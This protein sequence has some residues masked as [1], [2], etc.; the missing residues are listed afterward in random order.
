MY[1]SDNALEKL[2]NQSKKIIKNNNIKQSMNLISNLKNPVTN[3]KLGTKKAFK[4]Y[5]QII[6]DTMKY[7]PSKHDN[8]IDLFFEQIKEKITE[9]YSYV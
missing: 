8:N 7:N 3:D 5:S 1:I 6:R 9:A 4:I 2:I